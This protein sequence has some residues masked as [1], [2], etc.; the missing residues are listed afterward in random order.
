MGKIVCPHCNTATSLNPV[1]I[2][3][4]YAFMPDRSSEKESVYEK[5]VVRA[6]KLAEYSDEV[7]Y[8]IFQC[9]ACEERFVAKQQKCKDE[10]WV[11]AYPVLHKPVAE[12]IPEPI[13]GE[14]EE[15][16]LC[17]AVGAYRA[18]ASMCQR[19]LES[20]CQNKKVSGLNQLLDKGIISQGLFDRATEIRL[21]AGIIK[22]QRI[23]SVSKEDAE[24]LLA[25]LEVILNHIY[26]EPKRLDALRQKREQIEKKAP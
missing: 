7:S 11:V 23:E 22:H 16:S 20:L 19:T 4:E 10:D 15:A 26:V 24:Q 6:I 13:K 21:W 25:Y 9:Q 5:A 1:L 14:F 17:F 3:D 12:E 18:C 2:E 8:G